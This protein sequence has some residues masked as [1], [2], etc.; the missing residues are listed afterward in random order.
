MKVKP[1]HMLVLGA[2]QNGKTTY[3]NVLHRR[4]P[5]VS[6][7]V[8]TKGID[9]IWGTKVKRINPLSQ[10]LLHDKKLVWD[11][12]RQA[13][14]IDWKAADAELLTLW[15]KL[16]SVAQRTGWT[17]SRAPWCQIIVD[18]AQMWESDDS[19]RPR[20]LED[21]AARG[22]G[23][24]VRLVLVTQHPSGIRVKTRTN[25]ETRVVFRLGDEGHRVIKGWGWP[26]DEIMAN[27]EAKYHFSSYAP[28]L[29][30][31]HHKPIPLS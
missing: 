23:M 5:G 7:F 17:S 6:I 18:E 11:P 28:G 27:A 8:D 30:W 22:L 24:G 25:L 31:R 3:T 9:P 19:K 4:A 10:A 2:T 12:P 29:G 13:D 14:G 1:T 21:I 15:G 26:A 16:Q 20:T